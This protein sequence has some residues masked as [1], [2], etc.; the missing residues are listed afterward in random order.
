MASKEGVGS[1]FTVELPAIDVA[2]V[3]E[4]P[5]AKVVAPARSAANAPVQRVVLYIEDDVANFY[6]LERILQ[7]RKHIKLVSALHG[8]LGLE[9]ARSQRPDL[10]LLDLNLPDMTGEQ[11]LRSLKENPHTASIPVIAVTAFAMKGDEERI[12]EGG[13]E[14]YISKP[15]SVMMFLDTVKQFIGEGA[16]ERHANQFGRSRR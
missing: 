13:C 5:S 1:T 15:F 16:V 12:R 14:A 9:L 2:P 11:L 8:S 10:I 6:L 3:P 4:I 7:A